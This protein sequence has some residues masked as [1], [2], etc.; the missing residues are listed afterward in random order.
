[1][2][3][4]NLDEASTADQLDTSAKADVLF[5]LVDRGPIFTGTISASQ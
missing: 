4:D 3:L 5:M 1:V 2:D